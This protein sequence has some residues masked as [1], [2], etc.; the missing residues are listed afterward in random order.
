MILPI[1]LPQCFLAALP[2]GGFYRNRI[3][4]KIPMRMQADSTRIHPNGSV[5]SGNAGANLA[6]PFFARSPGPPSHRVVRMRRPQGTIGTDGTKG[7]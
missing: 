3:T 1:K 7:T 2:R 4:I 6:R 5:V